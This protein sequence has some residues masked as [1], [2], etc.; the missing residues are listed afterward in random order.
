[1]RLT[2]DLE[3]WRISLI[4][5][6]LSVAFAGALTLGGPPAAHESAWREYAPAAAGVVG[7]LVVLAG[8][9]GRKDT[10]PD[11]GSAAVF[12][13]PIVCLYLVLPALSYL[14]NLSPEWKVILGLWA[15]GGIVVARV[16]S[17]RRA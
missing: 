4:V 6:G 16:I 17:R 5:A 7:L 11:V 10:S 13:L 14:A 2:V 1:M 8:L 12:N 3:P 15:V 9:I